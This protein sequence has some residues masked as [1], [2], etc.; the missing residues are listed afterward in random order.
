LRG[1]GE[2][3]RPLSALVG[4]ALRP[5]GRLGALLPDLLGPFSL[6]G[7]IQTERVHVGVKEQLYAEKYVG[8]QHVQESCQCKGAS[9]NGQGAEKG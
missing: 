8:W 3:L 2:V 5:L 6:Q 7:Y 9:S 1:E 4:D